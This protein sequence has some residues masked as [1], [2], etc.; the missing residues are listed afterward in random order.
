MKNALIVVDAQ[1]DFCEGGALAATDTRSLL[2]PLEEVIDAT[3]RN[4]QL[5]V[6]TQD[7]H[8][9]DHSSF[10]RNGGRWPDHCVAGSSGAELM[11][12]LVAR[13]TDLIIRK[14]KMRDAD[15][16]SA[17]E[18]T[19]LA[20]QLRA[21]DIQSVAVSGVATEFCVRA[22]A[23]D[24]TKSGFKVAV[25]TDLIRPVAL[26]AT[27]GVLSELSN[28]GIDLVDSRAWLDSRNL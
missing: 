15:G 7:W 11:P 21:L 6:F 16:Y 22:T 19:G 23:L 5:I 18:S 3:R 1:R 13:A 24:A 2:R 17:F 25:L 9:S 27:A 8:P 12:P 20:D 14:G 26:E 10:E 4:G 28:A